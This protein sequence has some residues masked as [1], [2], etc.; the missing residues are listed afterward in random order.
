MTFGG[1][2]ALGSNTNKVDW[3]IRGLITRTELSELV[4]TPCNQTTRAACSASAK[5]AGSAY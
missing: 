2:L 5:K 4:Q 3:I 1:G